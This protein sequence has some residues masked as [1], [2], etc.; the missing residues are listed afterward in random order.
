MPSAFPVSAYLIPAL[1]SGQLFRSLLQGPLMRPPLRQSVC[2]IS[3][4]IIKS[5]PLTINGSLTVRLVVG[6]VAGHGFAK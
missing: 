2:F 4:A 6:L 5:V 3:A 1:G